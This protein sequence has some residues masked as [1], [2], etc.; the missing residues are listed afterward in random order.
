MT[1]VRKPFNKALYKT[2]DVSAKEKLV[3]LLENKGHT[4]VSTEENYYCDIISQKDGH[5]YFNEAEVKVGWDG[6]WPTHW[7]EIRI[8]ERKQRA[9]DRYNGSAGVLNFYIFRK[10]MKQ[11]WCIKENC[12]TKE[13]LKEAKG[14]Y[15]QKGE[16]FFHIPYTDAELIQ[17]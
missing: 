15:I 8:P 16:Q 5:T 14:R 1:A 13:S 2:Y 9:L 3:T 7:A 17:L 12:L 11:V 6:D 4:I 10:D